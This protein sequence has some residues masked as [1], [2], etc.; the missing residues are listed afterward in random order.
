MTD[1]PQH[2]PAGLPEPPELPA[3][4]AVPRMRIT[5]LHHV[6]LIS[7][8]LQRTTTFYRDVLGFALAGGLE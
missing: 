1:E 6:T 2:D 3:A 7:A 5:G 8:D 4:P